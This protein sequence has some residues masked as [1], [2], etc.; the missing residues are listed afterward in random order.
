MAKSMQLICGRAGTGR[1]TEVF[2]RIAALKKGGD[3]REVF[4][5]V[6]EQAT[7]EAE[8]GLAAALS[9]GLYGCTVTSWDALARKLLDAMGVKKA[10]LSGEG[11]VML[12]RRAAEYTAKELAVFGKTAERKGFPAECDG[13]INDFKRCGFS[14]AD[15]KRASESLDEGDPLKDKL[16]DIAI[17]FSELE[18]RFA[19]R[20]IDSEDMMRELALRMGESPIKDAHVFIDGGDT[21]RES[22]FPVLGAILDHAAS[23]TMTLTLDRERSGLFSEEE[24][25]LFRIKKL[26]DERGVSIS[27]TFLTEP[28][29]DWPPA[30]RHLERELFAPSPKKFEG[31]PDGLSIVTASSR[32][33]ETAEAAERIRQAVSGGARYRDIAVIV[34]D[35]EGYVPHIRRIFPTY[36]IPF[37]T[38][39]KRGLMTHPAAKLVLDALTAIEHGF[40]AAYVLDA[41]KSGYFPVSPD[42]IER[43]E[44]YLLKTGIS[45]K[46]LLEPFGDEG[47]ELED[48]RVRALTPLIDLRA[49]LENRA[50]DSRTRAVFAFLDELALPEKQ[51]E[52][53]ARLHAEGLYREESE[54]AQVVGT[55]FEVL[56]QLFVIMGGEQIGLKR[57]KAVLREGFEAYKIGNIPSTCDQV[58]VGSPD[59]TRSRE[60][61]LL[62]VMG[63]NDGL[64]PKPRKDEGVIGDADLARLKDKGFE[65]WKNTGSLSDG[66]TLNIYRAFSKARE[67]MVFSYTV[68]I[69]GAGSMDAA[70][71]P[72]ALLTNIRSVFPNIT[73][74]ETVFSPGGRSSEELAFASL[75]RRLRRMI[76]TGV[77]DDDAALLAAW[78]QRSP[79]YGGEFNKLTGLCF[80][81]EG[82]SP[83]GSE[84]A[85]SLYGR[86]LYGSASRLESFNGCPY[87]HF[88]QY[89]L[90]AKEREMREQKNTELGLFYHEALEGYVR[91]VME[92]G[93]DWRKI[94][95]EK[96]HAILKE[97]LPGIMYKK[98]GHL[99]Y[100]TA[101]Q[102]ARLWDVIETVRS[103]CCAVTRQIARGSFRPEGCEVSFG[104]PDSIFPALRI[105]A[106]GAEFLISGVIDRIDSAGDMNRIIDY[107]SGGKDFDFAALFHGL[108][109]QLPLYAAAANSA[110][111][112][113]MFYVPIKDIAPTDDGEGGVKKELTEKLLMDF[114]MS[115][116]LLREAE[117][118]EATEDFDGASTVVR[119]KYNKEGEL[120]GSGLVS[121]EELKFAVDYAKKR[122][123]GTLASILAGNIDISPCEMKTGKKST[124]CRICPYGDVCKFDPE[125]APGRMRSIY[126]MD[127]DAFFSRE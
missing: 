126:P 22:A 2:S 96:T 94:D 36:G 77:Q 58:L 26:A 101:R 72:C 34:S 124:A 79:E 30:V 60:V 120:I 122:A 114:R 11:R 68:S 110:E 59:R 104:R 29:R 35:Q 5:I 61:R 56:D 100:D 47:E 40:E 76:D 31:T 39:A 32:A 82:P 42:E 24:N 49:A 103:T 119:M 112:V 83:L 97:I 62:I 65:L 63:M 117:V 57:F 123:A 38:D 78:F 18:R 91:C 8:Q 102:R 66:D 45:G 21:M 54:N 106:G 64:F 6:T 19:D 93:L 85:S 84:L 43:L 127:A 15:V 113:G 81:D 71:A 4:L 88:V 3:E 67:S 75:G 10:F 14:A 1:T 111:T 17:I 28:K 69:E 99:L 107:K 86:L 92:N 73:E 41:L 53:C 74:I 108:Q 9:G 20:Y 105:E 33:D 80:P 87:R 98:G 109:L 118:I 23:V 37:F 46:K 12:V 116:V 89:G 51:R 125:L 90:M 27:R 25:V 48:I 95:D 55:V 16:N 7:F 115:G 70:A 13:I 52:L 44:N 50:C 121:G